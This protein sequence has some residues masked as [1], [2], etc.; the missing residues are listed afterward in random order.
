MISTVAVDRADARGL[1]DQSDENSIEV[2][3]PYTDSVNRDVSYGSHNHPKARTGKYMCG[4]A[5][6]HQAGVENCGGYQEATPQPS[7]ASK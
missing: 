1:G 7:T 2:D 5:H 4:E 3:P 6:R